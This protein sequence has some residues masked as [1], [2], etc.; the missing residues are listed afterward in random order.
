M[1]SE[2]I[3][4]HSVTWMFGQMPTFNTTW[5]KNDSV[6]A[7]SPAVTYTFSPVICGPMSTYNVGEVWKL[8]T[9]AWF[10]SPYAMYMLYRQFMPYRWLGYW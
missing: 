1:N 5:V 7:A 9:N 3:P 6:F 10:F 2:K 8:W 4:R